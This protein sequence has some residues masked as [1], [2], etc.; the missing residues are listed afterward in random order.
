MPDMPFTVVAG[1]YDGFDHNCK[2]V[3]KFT[4]LDAALEALHKV[5]DYP[6]HHIEY[7]GIPEAVIEIDARWVVR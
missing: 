3:E 5:A 1:K 2:Y 6:W 4:T 7:R